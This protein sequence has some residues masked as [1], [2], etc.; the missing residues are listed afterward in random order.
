MA[1]DGTT[2][3]TIDQ[4]RAKRDPKPGEGERKEVSIAQVGRVAAAAEPR[5]R[6]IQQ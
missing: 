5:L 1:S 6:R 4:I 3:L 2:E